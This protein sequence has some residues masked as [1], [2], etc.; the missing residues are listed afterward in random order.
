MEGKKL[1]HSISLKNLL[2]YGSEGV[3]IELEPLNVLI[4]PNASGKSN[5]IE[6]ISLLAAAPRNL[7]APFR[8]S[9]FAEDWLWKGRGKPVA[10][11]EASFE[12]PDSDERTRL[13]YS[14]Q[15]GV[16]GIRL[17]ILH[18]SLGPAANRGKFFF[19]DKNVAGA[20]RAGG[21]SLE[22]LHGRI[23]FDP[24]QS[25]FVHLKD[26]IDYPFSAPLGDQL[27]RV[28]F[29]RGWPFGRHSILR[30]PQDVHLPDDFLLE[31][32]SNLG[33]ILNDLQNH[34]ETKL[35]ILENLRL[36][37]EDVEDVTTKVQ[38]G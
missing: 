5:L 23:D 32:G 11:L 7:L 35:A 12:L 3:T 28:R 29:F 25:L 37:Y 15:F 21:G 26:P 9:G 38:G 14:L 18:E 34:R 6:A 31:D 10:E 20:L 33:L 17:D 16:Q 30:K 2:S 22:P 27:G 36:L 1:L 19:R 24:Q 8:D 4:G 13:F